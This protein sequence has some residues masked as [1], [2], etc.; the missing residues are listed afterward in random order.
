MVHRKA[1]E[2]QHQCAAL[3]VL[4]SAGNGGSVALVS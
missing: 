3:Q 2:I 1:H 4:V